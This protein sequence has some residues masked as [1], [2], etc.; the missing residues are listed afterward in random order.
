MLLSAFTDNG[1]IISDTLV[2]LEI[3]GVHA[4]VMVQLLNKRVRP[5]GVHSSDAALAIIDKDTNLTS[6]SLKKVFGKKSDPELQV[7]SAADGEERI[8]AGLQNLYK[9]NCPNALPPTALFECRHAAFPWGELLINPCNGDKIDTGLESFLVSVHS[10]ID[11]NN[12]QDMEAAIYDRSGSRAAPFHLAKGRPTPE[13]FQ[14]GLNA[15]EMAHIYHDSER[16]T[17]YYV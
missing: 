11:S 5:T 4:Y 12:S 17:K 13:S 15:R 1:S 8:K 3:K 10:S 6:C 16:D 9:T 2:R 14:A 7:D